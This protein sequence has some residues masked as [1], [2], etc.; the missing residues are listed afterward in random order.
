MLATPTTTQ[1]LASLLLGTDLSEWVS[2]RRNPA[3]VRRSWRVI[4][5]ELRRQTEGEVDV[6][7]ETLRGWFKSLDEDDEQVAS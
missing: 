3:D 4:A 1:R 6:T 5:N 7:G 2:E